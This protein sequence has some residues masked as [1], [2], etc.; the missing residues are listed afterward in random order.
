MTLRYH[1]VSAAVSRGCPEPLGR[2]P[3]VTHPCAAP[4]L[5]RALD[6]HVLGM[7]PAFVLSQDQTLRLVQASLQALRSRAKPFRP[8]TQPPKRQTVSNPLSFHTHK[9]KRIRETYSTAGK[10][11]RNLAPGTRRPRIPSYRRIQISNIVARAEFLAPR[12]LGRRGLYAWPAR[13]VKPFVSE[14]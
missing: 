2:F 1:P 10:P 5:L 4:V 6:L 11:K 14:S 9:R 8:V 12:P 3:R 13:R 7:P